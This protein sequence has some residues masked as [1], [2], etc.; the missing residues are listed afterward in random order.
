MTDVNVKNEN[1]IQCIMFF[2]DANLW[3]KEIKKDRPCLRRRRTWRAGRERCACAWSGRAATRPAWR[4]AVRIRPWARRRSASRRRRY[5]RGTARCQG[6]ARQPARAPRP[7]TECLARLLP[8]FSPVQ[9]TRSVYP[10]W[11]VLQNLSDLEGSW[12]VF[13]DFIEFHWA[14]LC[15]PSKRSAKE[16]SVCFTWL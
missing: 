12:A 1:R 16:V 9:K 11:S 7:G 10:T 5:C 8:F 3:M 6:E 15:D 14:T 13:N 2:V 4:R